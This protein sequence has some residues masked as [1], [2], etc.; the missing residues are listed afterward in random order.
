[1]PTA[2]TECLSIEMAASEPW[3]PD[4]ALYTPYITEQVSQSGERPQSRG[5]LLWMRPFM[6]ELTEM[7]CYTIEQLSFLTVV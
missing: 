1:M 3:A 4:A 5:G 7:L 6:I 2:L